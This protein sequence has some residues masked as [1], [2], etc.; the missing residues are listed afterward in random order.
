MAGLL[1]FEHCQPG[2][3]LFDILSDHL[4][5]KPIIERFEDFLFRVAEIGDLVG[6]GEKRNGG[7]VDGFALVGV[8]GGTITRSGQRSLA[9]QM[10]MPVL[11]P[12]G[13]AI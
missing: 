5:L 10:A 12:N 7:D 6:C 4:Q 1:L 3:T 9:C 13:F 8:S 11:T 2:G